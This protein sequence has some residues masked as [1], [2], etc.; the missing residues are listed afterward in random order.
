MSEDRTKELPDANPFEKR[1]LMLFDRVFA[2]LADMRTQ[3]ADMRTELAA[4]RELQDS[5]DEKVDRRL[6]ETRPIWEA[7]LQEVRATG[8]RV[9]ALAAEVEVIKEDVKR[10]DTK[11][12]VMVQELFEHSADI[13]I[14]KKRVTQ[15]EDH[16]PA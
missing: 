2:E 14:L 11:F 9:G 6:Q 3:Q 8:E 1:V 4:I 5:L 13:R 10:I 15:I 12:E 7:V 16:N